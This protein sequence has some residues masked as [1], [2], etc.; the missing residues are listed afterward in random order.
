MKDFLDLEN[1]GLVLYKLYK[2][3]L[4]VEHNIE[5]FYKPCPQIADA[6]IKDLKEFNEVIYLLENF[7]LKN[8][9]IDE[10]NKFKE[11]FCKSEL[12]KLDKKKY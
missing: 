6:L 5:N 7:G 11:K 4:K 9:D 2:E 1:Y 10:Y 12:K 3:K 8:I